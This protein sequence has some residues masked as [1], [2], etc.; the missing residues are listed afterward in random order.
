MVRVLVAM[1]I[2]VMGLSLYFSTVAPVYACSGNCESITNTPTV[3]VTLNGSDQTLSYPLAF[4]LNNIATGG[5]HVS[6]SSTQF[7]TG[8]TPVHLLPAS[9]SSVTGV[10]S[11][12]QPGQSCTTAPQNVMRYP[13]GVPLTPNSLPFYDAQPNSGIGTFDVTAT[14]ALTVPANAFKGSYTSTITLAL[15]DGP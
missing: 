3:V 9:A 4:S 5:W 10:A 8:S 14:V 13:I 11:V 12:C 2:L 6:I 7:A 1:T 15:S